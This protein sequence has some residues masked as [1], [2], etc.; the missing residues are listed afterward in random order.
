[1]KNSITISKATYGRAYAHADH[2]T[3]L[4][5]HSDLTIWQWR[6]LSSGNTT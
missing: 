3:S 4:V 2:D 6:A 1:M 5:S